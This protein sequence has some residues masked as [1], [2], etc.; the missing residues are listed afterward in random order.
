MI[1]VYLINELGVYDEYTFDFPG[2]YFHWL[3]CTTKKWTRLVVHIAVGTDY[4]G[5]TKWM[6]IK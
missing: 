1:Q 3:A 4:D 2:E 5:M 6:V